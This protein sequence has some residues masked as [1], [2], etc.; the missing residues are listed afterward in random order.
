MYG[1]QIR[2]FRWYFNI[3]RIFSILKLQKYLISKPVIIVI[4]NE[5]SHCLIYWQIQWLEL[6][7]EIVR[8]YQDITVIF[9]TQLLQCIIRSSS[10]EVFFRKG[11]LKVCSKFAKEHPYRSVISIKF[12]KQLYWNRFSAWVFSCKF[13]AYFR[14]P[15]PKN[16]SGCLILYD[17]LAL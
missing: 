5:W 16:T 13:A 8:Y 9:S 14:T 10:P 6:I 17:C 3:G 4:L 1:F 2:Q 15:F 12:L 11:V 7:S